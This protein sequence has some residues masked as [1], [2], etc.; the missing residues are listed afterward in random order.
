MCGV[1]MGAGLANHLA[2]LSLSFTSHDNLGGILTSEYL[3]NINIMDININDILNKIIEEKIK[4]TKKK[5]KN[6]NFLPIENFLNFKESG[7]IPNF[8]TKK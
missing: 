8:L 2:K 3:I 1:C 5:F 7:Q 6:V 4:A